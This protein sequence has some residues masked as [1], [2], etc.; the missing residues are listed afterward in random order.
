MF[1]STGKGVKVTVSLSRKASAP[2]RGNKNKSCVNCGT[3]GAAATPAT[4]VGL[5]R[6]NF[7]T[8]K[9]TGGL[10]AECCDVQLSWLNRLFLFFLLR[11]RR[12]PLFSHYR[13]KPFEL[14]TT[15]GLKT[16]LMS[17]KP[18]SGRAHFDELSSVLFLSSAHKFV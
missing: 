14:C 13:T 2:K 18:Q 11:R 8:D 10:D 15:K 16:C 9:T 7:Q 12:L 3:T 1:V 4:I 5:K 17:R 6:N